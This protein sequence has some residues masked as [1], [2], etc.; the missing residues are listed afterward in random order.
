VC[1]VAISAL[2]QLDELTGHRPVIEVTNRFMREITADSLDALQAANDPPTLFQRG[3]ELVRVHDGQTEAEPLTIAALRGI[4]DRAADYVRVRKTKDGGEELIPTRPPND[5][6]ADIMSLPRLPFPELRAI[7]YV[8][9]FVP[10]GKLLTTDGY[11]PATGILLRL[12]G[13]NDVHA[14]MPLEQAKRY[15]LFEVLGDFPFADPQAGPAHAVAMILQPFIRPMIAGPTPAYSVDAPAQGTG[16]GLLTEVA[17]L[18]ASGSPA[19]VMAL[20]GNEEEI[21]KRIT[22]ILLSATSHILIDNVERLHSTSLAAALTAE[23]WRGRRL[24][25]SEM[26]HVRNE[27]TWMITGNNIDY[28]NE[29]ARRVVP[30]RLDAGVERPENRKGFRHPNLPQWVREHRSELV[31]ACLSIVQHWVDAGMPKGTKTLGRFEAWAEVMGGILDVAGIPGFL[32]GRE[33][34]YATAD[35]DTNEWTAFCAA[36]HE[37]FPNEAVTAG[38]L[39]SIAKD[40]EL[41][42]DVWAG[43]THAGAVRRLGHAL[44]DRRDRVFGNYRI[45]YVGEDTK[46]KS[47][48]YVV[49]TLRGSEKNPEN[50]DIPDALVKTS[51][52]SGFPNAGT[53]GI[54]KENPDETPTKPRNPD[55]IPTESRQ[56]PDSGNPDVDGVC[57]DEPGVF[58]IFGVLNGHQSRDSGA[59][60]PGD[61]E[62]AL[63]RKGHATPSRG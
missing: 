38:R 25:K 40:N 36:W 19:P 1:D 2:L 15:L 21:E 35:R 45:R 4:L 11:D 53:V 22:A 17:S 12:Q 16:K 18:I 13:L 51:S 42:L 28:S 27:A 26:L 58:G 5:V 31:S 49:E 24:G 7:S 30:I 14:T 3:G 62:G 50:P 10:G 44:R 48:G 8:P 57:E 54:L 34:L 6:A 59:P 60:D 46:T 37:K 52:T 9:T 32:E 61:D 43:R 56:N 23:V 20:A 33:R 47:A 39:L 63:V 41:L 55:K 29:L